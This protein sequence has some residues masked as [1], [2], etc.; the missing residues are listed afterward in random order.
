LQ[1]SSRSF[2]AHAPTIQQP[3]PEK[4]LDF[5]QKPVYE[6]AYKDRWTSTPAQEL[7]VMRLLPE[8]C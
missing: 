6:R 8:T 2:F 3:A 1:S 5:K 4:I 7:T